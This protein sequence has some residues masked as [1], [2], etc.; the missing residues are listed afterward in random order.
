LNRVSEKRESGLKQATGKIEG[1]LLGRIHSVI[2]RSEIASRQ[3]KTHFLFSG[4]NYRKTASSCSM[5]FLEIYFR[6]AL[7]PSLLPSDGRRWPEVDEGFITRFS[8]IA[9]G[10]HS[11][12]R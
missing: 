8:E 4:K 6:K 9:F 5:A 1:C 10:K 3:P 11:I 2:P 12:H 7:I